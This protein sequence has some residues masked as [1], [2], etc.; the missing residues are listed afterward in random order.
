MRNQKIQL[1]SYEN[2]SFKFQERSS[3]VAEEGGAITICGSS[4]A[5]GN[6]TWNRDG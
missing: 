3:R 2:L 4:F 5:F 6:I 1:L